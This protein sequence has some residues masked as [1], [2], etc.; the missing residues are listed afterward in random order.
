MYLRVISST[1]AEPREDL[2]YQR[3]TYETA[4]QT[5]LRLR[6]RIRSFLGK[7]RDTLSKAEVDYF[8]RFNCDK[9]FP[10]NQ[11][12]RFR[13]TIKVHKGPSVPYTY[14]PIV[15]CAGTFMICSLVL[16]WLSLEISGRSK[17]VSNGRTVVPLRL[18]IR[19]CCSFLV[20]FSVRCMSMSGMSS[21]VCFCHES[22]HL[23]CMMVFVCLPI[24]VH[25]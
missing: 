7:F 3:I 10:T 1:S 4:F 18:L 13:M 15:C 8:Q 21:F 6:W 19:S 5:N 16:K 24:T 14:R 20:R 23:L 9:R 25:W 12:A 17:C 22:L 11:F 2:S